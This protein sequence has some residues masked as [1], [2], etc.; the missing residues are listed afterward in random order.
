MGFFRN[1]LRW[2][3]RKKEKKLTLL[4]VGVNNAGKSTLISALK[5][6]RLNTRES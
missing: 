5:G 4:V 1:F 3:Q 6:G 2:I